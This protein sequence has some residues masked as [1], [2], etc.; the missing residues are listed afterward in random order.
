MIETPLRFVLTMLSI[1]G[2]FIIRF[3]K[4]SSICMLFLEILNAMWLSQPRCSC[5][6]PMNCL[7]LFK[8]TFDCLFSQLTIDYFL[9][10]LY[11]SVGGIL[12]F[13]SSTYFSVG[14]S[15]L[16]LVSTVKFYNVCFS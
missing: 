7:L 10:S 8:F 6:R 4:F 15:L 16:F 1:S 12:L 9:T 2:P 3:C 14:G 11:F 13:L 5:L